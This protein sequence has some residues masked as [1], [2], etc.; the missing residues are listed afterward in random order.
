MSAAELKNAMRLG[1]ASPLEKRHKNDLGRFGLGMKTASFSICKRLTVI[2]SVEGKVSAACW[3]LDEITKNNKWEITIIPEKEIKAI[4]F[5][6]HLPANGTAIVWEKIDHMIDSNAKHRQKELDSAIAAL[7]KHLCLT[8]HRFIDGELG[9]CKVS[10]SINGHQL[11]S[12]DPFNKKNPATQ[13]LERDFKLENWSVKTKL[14]SLRGKATLGPVVIKQGDLLSLSL[15]IDGAKDYQWKKNSVPISG[16]NEAVYSKPKA[17]QAD[18][19]TYS[20][21]FKYEMD[22]IFVDIVING[23]EVVVTP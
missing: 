23:I 16:A 4:A 3:D 13:E 8:F 1:S 10:I 12:F 15:D 22:S 17:A 5:I 21:T 20:V 9:I 11:Q 19:G 14:A 7:E 18:S 2:S 6:E